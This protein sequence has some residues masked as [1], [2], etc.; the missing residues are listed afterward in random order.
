VVRRADRFVEGQPGGPVSQSLLLTA[1]DGAFNEVQRRKEEQESARISF[2]GSERE[3]REEF[4]RTAKRNVG[5]RDH[6]VR[7]TV[8]LEAA[9]GRA[10]TTKEDGDGKIP[11]RNG[12]HKEGTPWRKRGRG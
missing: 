12:P 5:L 6:V 9:L 4:S 7:S 10:R 11:L 3:E 8:W 1:R 2:S